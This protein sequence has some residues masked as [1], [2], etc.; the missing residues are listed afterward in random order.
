MSN[1]PFT[2]YWVSN[3]K[4]VVSHYLLAFI[5]AAVCHYGQ[6]CMNGQYMLISDQHAMR[7]SS[8]SKITQYENSQRHRKVKNTYNTVLMICQIWMIAYINVGIFFWLLMYLW[9]FWSKLISTD[10]SKHSMAWSKGKLLCS[11]RCIIESFSC[12]NY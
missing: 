9:N 5:A 8:A 7:F 11:A 3:P 1:P 4:T 10:N 6:K 2:N 12:Q